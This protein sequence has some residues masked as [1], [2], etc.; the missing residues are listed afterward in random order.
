MFNK[1]VPAVVVH[2]RLATLTDASIS[3]LHHALQTVGVNVPFLPLAGGE[4]AQLGVLVFFVVTG[5]EAIEDV[6]EILR[7]LR[8]YIARI[9]RRGRVSIR[10]ISVKKGT[11][12]A[13]HQLAV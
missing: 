11:R 6:Q 3:V 1:D 13:V 5:H 2:L 9:Q 7:R 4:L 10:R 8:R 12:K